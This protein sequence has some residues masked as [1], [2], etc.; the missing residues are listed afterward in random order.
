MSWLSPTMVCALREKWCR[1]VRT[2][3]ALEE[4]GL[5]K[6]RPC[7]DGGLSGFKLVLVP[8]VAD[9]PALRGNRQWL[10]IDAEVRLKELAERWLRP[11][12]V[13]VKGSVHAIGGMMVDDIEVNG[14]FL[15]MPQAEITKIARADMLYDTVNVTIVVEQRMKQAKTPEAPV[16]RKRRR[17]NGPTRED[18]ERAAPELFECP[19]CRRWGI[20]KGYVCNYCGKDPGGPVRDQGGEFR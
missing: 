19:H 7:L 4:R 15:E 1:T 9:E 18:L 3:I 11:E 5:I 2:A 16:D 17:T 6:E 8:G 10:P 20:I 13:Q 12:A 14:V